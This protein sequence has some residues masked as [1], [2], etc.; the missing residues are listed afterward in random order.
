[1]TAGTNAP[2]WP[3]VV[4][5]V[6][7]D[8]SAHVTVNG[9]SHPIHTEDIHETRRTVIDLVREE[10]AVVL[11]R[12]VRVDTTDPAG[13][14]QLIVHPDGH[15]DEVA[16]PPSARGRGEG[17]RWMRRTPPRRHWVAATAAA[18]ALAMGGALVAIPKGGTDRASVAQPTPT[19]SPTPADAPVVLRGADLIEPRAGDSR[20]ARARARARART[21]RAE[22]ARRSAA[23]QRRLQRERAAR[24][25]ERERR[26][27]EQRRRQAERRSQP[28][29]TPPSAPAPAPTATPAPPVAQRPAPPAPAPPSSGDGGGGSDWGGEFSP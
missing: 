11:G 15:V 4:A 13:Q 18:V 2:S 12:P 20:V 1:M 25:R 29:P 19:A 8:G 14:W 24:R 17:G 22:Q 7:E 3:K 5:V 23:R 6:Q 28:S 10:A 26:R 16:A 21:A 27:A 9:T